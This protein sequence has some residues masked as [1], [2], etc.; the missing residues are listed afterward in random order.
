MLRPHQTADE[1]EGSDYIKVRTRKK[2]D[3]HFVNIDLELESDE[4]LETLI[5]EL[6]DGVFT[7]DRLDERS[8]GLELSIETRNGMDFYKSYDDTEDLVGGVDIH[9]EEFCKLIENLSSKSKEIWDKCHRKEFDI[10]FESG[11]TPKSFRTVIQ[12][13]TVKRC[14]EI[15]ASITIT[16]YPHFNFDFIEKKDL[17]KKKLK[18]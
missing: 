6:G 18:K 7:L 10:G 12:S 5:E 17:K 8:I 13:E 4:S 16:V 15:G 9:I 11:N 3:F 2:I 1:I 14:A